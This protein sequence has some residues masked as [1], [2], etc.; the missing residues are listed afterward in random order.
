[1]VL[2]RVF[3]AFLAVSVALVRDSGGRGGGGEEDLRILQ[4]VRLP[5]LPTAESLT[6]TSSGWFAAANLNS[7]APW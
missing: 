1:M 5:L 4:L 6:D 3:A 2:G 7:E